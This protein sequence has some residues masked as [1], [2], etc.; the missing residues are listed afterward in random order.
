[1]QNGKFTD[2][3]L[4]KSEK[5]SFLNYGIKA[6]LVY[7]LSGM[8]YI[9]ADGAYLTKAPD[10]VNA[11]VSPRT[12]NQVV[13]GLSSETIYS[14]QGGYVLQSSKV[15]AIL[16]VFYAQFNDQTEVRSFYFDDYNSFVNFVM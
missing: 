10:F 12:R 2:N 8:H 6:G 5:L 4:G 16:D 14:V 9:H 13:D 3:S 11:F 7:K 15:K 1:M